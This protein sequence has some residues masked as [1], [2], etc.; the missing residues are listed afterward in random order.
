MPQRIRLTPRQ[1]AL[2]PQSDDSNAPADH[3]TPRQSALA[4][5]SNDSN[6]PADPPH[7]PRQSTLIP[8]K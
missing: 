5:L 3:L 8:L 6:A 1:S 4:P 2:A 7:I